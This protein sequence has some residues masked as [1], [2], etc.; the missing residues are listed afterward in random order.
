MKY[1][2]GTVYEGEFKDGLREGFGRMEYPNLD[3]YEG[4]WRE[5]L[6]HGQGKYYYRS[7]DST[8][9]G[10]FV[11]GRITTGEL[12]LRDGSKWVGGFRLNQPFGEGRW[13]NAGWAQ[14]GKY[15]ELNPPE[16]E[17][18]EEEAEP[19]E[20]AVDEEDLEKSLEQ[21]MAED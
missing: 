2:N 5:G 8:A 14:T 12:L 15:I 20:A 19:E 17:A 4:E 9:S 1:A 7:C 10:E 21:E 13:L 16:I 18:G 11:Y 6:P 3:F